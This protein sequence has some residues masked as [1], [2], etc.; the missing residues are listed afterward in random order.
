MAG[1]KTG[2][3]F[4]TLDQLLT[5]LGGVE[6]R[7]VKLNPPPGRATKRDPSTIAG[8]TNT[9]SWTVLS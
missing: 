9:N 2:L 5:R 4:E 1:T 6:P 8:R 7:R 3:P